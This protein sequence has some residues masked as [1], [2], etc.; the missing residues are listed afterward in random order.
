MSTS[1]VFSLKGLG[2]KLDTAEQMQ[3]HLDALQAL[4]EGVTEIHLGGN[5]LGVP[6]CEALAAVIPTLKNLKVSRA[7]P[8]L[9]GGG[10][11][12]AEGRELGSC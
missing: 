6:A 1:T 11:A 10:W 5:T 12:G 4:G 8:A 7:H 3:P 2:L 9:V